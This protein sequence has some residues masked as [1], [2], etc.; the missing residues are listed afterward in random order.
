MYKCVSD[1]FCG[2]HIGDG[3]WVTNNDPERKHRSRN[4]KVYGSP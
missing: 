3:T 2:C 1:V 4:G